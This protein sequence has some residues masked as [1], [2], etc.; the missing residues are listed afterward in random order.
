MVSGGVA[1]PLTCAGAAGFGP[2]VSPGTP[3]CARPLSRLL[4]AL[5]LLLHHPLSWEHHPL[6][7]ERMM[8]SW[9]AHAAWW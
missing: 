6:P 9:E 1:P 2:C 7:R 4:S 3:C 8:L 5:S